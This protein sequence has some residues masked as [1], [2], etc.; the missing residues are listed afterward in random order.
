MA[1]QALA[2]QKDAQLENML[3]GFVGGAST[4]EMKADLAAKGLAPLSD[5][6]QRELA[7]KMCAAAAYRA[8]SAAARQQPLAAAARALLGSGLPR[9]LPEPERETQRKSE[10]PPYL[11]RVCCARVSTAC[12]AGPPR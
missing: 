12:A 4:E 6:E 7:K 3:N 8:P 10:R 9:T 1:G 11:A 5:D 2:D